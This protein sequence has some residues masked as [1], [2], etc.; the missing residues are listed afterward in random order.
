MTPPDPETPVGP[1]PATEPVFARRGASLAL[2]VAGVLL[3]IGAAALVVSAFGSIAGSEGKVSLA[4]AAAVAGAAC[5]L[6]AV[7]ASV[8]RARMRRRVPVG[9][10]LLAP[11]LFAVA[12]YGVYLATAEMR[13]L[14]R[15]PG[16]FNVHYLSGDSQIGLVSGSGAWW[17]SLDACPGR[18]ADAS[19]SVTPGNGFADVTFGWADAA[20][21]AMRLHVAERR[22]E[23]FGPAGPPALPYRMH[24]TFGNPTDTP[25]DVQTA[26]DLH[27]DTLVARFEDGRT[28]RSVPTDADWRAF[29]ASIDSS[30]VDRWGMF[31]DG[32]DGADGLIWTVEIR[33]PSLDVTGGSRGAYPGAEGQPRDTQTPEFDRYVRA[34]ERLVG[35]PVR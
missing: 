26:I 13:E 15:T 20:L 8:R 25:G 30:A 27:S 9:A 7:V 23:C 22:V 21:P 1:A 11:V 29:R 4:V 33:A 5:I 28:A 14:R 18:V 6:L 2:A 32:L 16:V 3:W 24:L 17:V 31:T 19:A 12:G 34:V 10:L 35:R